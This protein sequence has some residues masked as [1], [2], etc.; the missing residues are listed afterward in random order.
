LT[1]LKLCA[2]TIKFVVIKYIMF[3]LLT[4]IDLERNS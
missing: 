3:I 1:L 2:A 4:Y